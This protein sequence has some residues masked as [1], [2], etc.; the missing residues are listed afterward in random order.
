VTIGET[1]FLTT[2]QGGCYGKHRPPR[3]IACIGVSLLVKPCYVNRY[4]FTIVLTPHA[5]ESWKRR[6]NNIRYGEVYGQLNEARMRMKLN[7]VSGIQLNHGGEEVAYLYCRRIF[8][9]IR[10]REEFEVI[11]VTPPNDF[12]SFGVSQ[13]G[14]Q[15]D[16]TE[17]VDLLGEIKRYC[18]C[19]RKQVTEYKEYDDK[20]I[21]KHHGFLLP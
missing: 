16:E 9:Y 6:I 5:R 1:I 11:S 19:C 17:L 13:N 7:I 8:N 15:H 3:R 14:H 20:F 21:C 10:C 12:H 4:G 18:F 2:N